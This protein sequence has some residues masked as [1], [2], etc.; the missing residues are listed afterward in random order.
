MPILRLENINKSYNQD[1]PT[2]FQALKNVSFSVEP[3]EFISIMGPSGS[4]KSTLLNIIGILDV[5]DTGSYQLNGVEI[6]SLGKSRLPAIRRKEI[7]FIFQTFNLLPRLSVFQNV[8]MPLMYSRVQSNKQKDRVDELLGLVKLTQRR[9]YLPTKLSGGEK[10]R[11][12]IARA[13][14][15]NPSIIL[16]DEPT[17]NLDSKSGREIMEAL[18]ELNRQGRTILLVTHD[19]NIADF[20]QRHF[21]MADGVLTEGGQKS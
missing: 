16:A 6:T 21:F 2:A 3:G 10:Q 9:N 14:A 5:A 13:L 11:V 4:G 18:A 20:A 12:A 17:G 15:N 19:Q 7:G 1:T 8:Q